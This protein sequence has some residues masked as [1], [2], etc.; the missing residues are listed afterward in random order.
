MSTT[1]ASLGFPDGARAWGSG[2]TP[3]DRTDL[4]LSLVEN[5]VA[6]AR[7]WADI[8]GGLPG[9]FDEPELIDGVAA[10]IDR[11][12]NRDQRADLTTVL[13]AASPSSHAAKDAVEK[14]AVKLLGRGTN[15]DEKSALSLVPLL[16]GTKA[17]RPGLKAAIES[18]VNGGLRLTTRDVAA[19]SSGGVD[20]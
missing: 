14:L 2:S 6:L 15:T 13:T 8:L 10:R 5:D 18:S 7:R 19:L 4:A 20:L 17:R 1:H 12:S 3:A 16:A 11:A 9:G